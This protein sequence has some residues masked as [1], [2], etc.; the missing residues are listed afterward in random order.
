M[1]TLILLIGPNACGKTTL[2]EL[3]TLNKSHGDYAD[4]KDIANWPKAGRQ[5]FVNGQNLLVVC[6][7]HEMRP[8][9]RLINAFNHIQKLH[10]PEQTLIWR[11][12]REAPA[13]SHT[14]KLLQVHR[15]V[16]FAMISEAENIFT[17]KNNLTEA[18]KQKR[19]KKERQKLLTNAYLSL[20][21]ILFPHA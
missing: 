20:N 11:V 6:L 14:D 18:Q 12:Q 10:Q 19:A 21:Q 7:D 4:L 3:L 17:L 2:A 16:R 13:D 5:R 1:K 9:S 15:N 8:G